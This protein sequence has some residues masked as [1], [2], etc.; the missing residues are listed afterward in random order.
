MII[1]ICVPLLT[2]LYSPFR[3]PFSF[4][5]PTLSKG[6]SEE[7]LKPEFALRVDWKDTGEEAAQTSGPSQDQISLAS[8]FESSSKSTLFKVGS[9]KSH[10]EFWSNSVQASD[11]II[12][13]IVDGYRIPFFD[14]PPSYAIP[15]Q[16][17][18]FKFKDFLNE[19][20]SELIECGCV[21]EVD[22][23]P[24]FINLLHVVQH[25]SGK[26]RLRPCLHHATF[27]L[28]CKKICQR[29]AI[30]SVNNFLH[31]PKFL[32]ALRNFKDSVD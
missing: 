23:P 19:G 4:G 2:V 15:N 31:P 18:A 24:V 32:Q 22:I 21:M 3:S 11:F 29:E 7:D 25:S 12:S 9:L 5:R 27:C 20:I 13:T 28:F 14:L 30:S 16:S 8:E 1:C 17:S 10:V 26:C 6:F